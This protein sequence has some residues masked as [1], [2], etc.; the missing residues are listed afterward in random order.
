MDKVL[1]KQGV[2]VNFKLRDP[3]GG[4]SEINDKNNY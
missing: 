4:S 2:S 3:R 1:R